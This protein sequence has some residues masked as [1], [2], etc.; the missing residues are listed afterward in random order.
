MTD[1]ELE[2]DR[3]IVSNLKCVLLIASCYPAIRKAVALGRVTPCGRNQI[4]HFAT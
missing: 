2:N 3:I 4:N 1:V